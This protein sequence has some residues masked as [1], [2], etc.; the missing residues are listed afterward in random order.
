LLAL[1]DC[2]A[3][4]TNGNKTIKPDS[5]AKTKHKVCIGG[6]PCVLGVIIYGKVPNIAPKNPNHKW[7][8][9]VGVMSKPHIN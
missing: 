1:A 7:V 3:N 5:L 4:F 6:D 2:Q 8:Y 9:G